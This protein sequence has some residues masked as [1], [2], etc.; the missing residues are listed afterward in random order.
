MQLGP[1][2]YETEGALA[3]VRCGPLTDMVKVSQGIIYSRSP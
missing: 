3:M 1:M 2:A